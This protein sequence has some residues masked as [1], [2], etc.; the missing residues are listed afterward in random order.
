M[1]PKD[2]KPLFDYT[3]YT[4]S[5]VDYNLCEGIKN[6]LDDERRGIN[7]Y[8]NDDYERIVRLIKSSLI[9]M[10]LRTS[11]N[12][13]LV[14]FY[15]TVND[16]IM[17]TLVEIL[18]RSNAIKT[19][20]ICF[21]NLGSK[22]G[23]MLVEALHRNI[24]SESLRINDNQLGINEGRTN[25]VKFNFTEPWLSVTYI[26]IKEHHG[27]YLNFLYATGSLPTSIDA[28]IPKCQKIEITCESHDQGWS[29]YPQDQG[30]YNNSWTWG[31]IT[32]IPK[33]N[34]DLQGQNESKTRYKVY[35]NKHAAEG[36]QTHNFI[37]LSDH[38]LVQSLQPG[39]IVGLY[40]RSLHPGWCNYIKRAEIKFYYTV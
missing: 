23:K 19:L 34:N 31:E 4:K 9:S 7:Y 33:Q 27:T 6:W 22:E 36:W 35:T 13:N 21:D 29:S 32:I 40:I 24:T 37:F 38:P 16:K 17:M 11:N 28:G 25:H 39:D 14:D 20:N 30:T 12:L 5:I 18:Y 15:E 3:A 26:K 10:I 2:P 1:F 8:S